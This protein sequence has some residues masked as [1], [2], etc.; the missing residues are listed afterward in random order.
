MERLKELINRKPSRWGNLTIKVF[1]RDLKILQEACND[2]IAREEYVKHLQ[3]E[4][5]ELKEKAKQLEQELD[6]LNL[7]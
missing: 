2:L 7:L 1:E 5:E 3:T 4:N 6:Q